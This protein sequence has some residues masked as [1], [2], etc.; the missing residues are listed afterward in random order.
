[1]FKWG[2]RM[3]QE[4]CVFCGE[5]DVHLAWF[6]VT[7]KSVDVQARVIK[8]LN[9][10]G[11]DIRFGYFTGIEPPIGVPTEVP[12]EVKY[13][14]FTLVDEKAD[15]DELAA[16]LSTLDG[17]IDAD[18]NLSHHVSLQPA[19][20]PQELLGERAII[21]RATTF[22]DI[23]KI[24][25][26][27]VPQSDTL[28]FLAGLRGGTDAAKYFT[29][30]ARLERSNLTMMLSELLSICGWGR[31][32]IEFDFQSLK[33]KIKVMDSYI[34]D[35]LGRSESP[36]CSYMSGYFAGFFSEVLGEN[37]YVSETACKSTGSPYCEH[38]IC[39]APHFNIE[40]LAR[41]DGT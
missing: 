12:T 9:E 36:V 1:M 6:K 13:E 10:H 25:N 39:Q 30:T 3:V 24:L 34:A 18:Q 21:I 32:Q 35:T 22:V 11:A 41:G 15:V 38:T 26:E 19:K 4:L 29:R 16:G 7:M 2:V 23:L 8:Y 37:M 40:H 27:N 5:E 20:F 31:A 28:L 14:L 33:G 17:V